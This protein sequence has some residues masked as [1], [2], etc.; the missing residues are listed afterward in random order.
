MTDPKHKS[1]AEKAVFSAKG[2]KSA[3]KKDT[4]KKQKTA[5]SAEKEP[6]FPLRFVM[7]AVCLILFV[8]FLIILL[9]SDG[10][11]L[12]LIEN[13]LTGLIGHVA[14]VILTPAL[15]YLFFILAF[16]GKRPVLMRS[17]CLLVFVFLCGCIAHLSLNPQNLPK[18]VTLIWALYTG[19][20]AGTTSGVLCGGF[21]MLVYLLC[22]TVGSY[23]LFVTAAVIT[24]LGAMQ[25]TLPSIIRAIQNRPRGD[26]EK[27]KAEEKPEPAAVVVNIWQISVLRMWRKRNSG[28][29]I[30]RPIRRQPIKTAKKGKVFPS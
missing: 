28:K 20:S 17:I 7:S 15:L 4:A 24:L 18:D 1:Q 8:F 11:L 2:K 3:A 22:G 26:W 29:Q 19:G 6:I 13:I 14:F 12:N 16:S 25:I 27:S 9:Q 5:G 21:T 30:R 23:V 10:I